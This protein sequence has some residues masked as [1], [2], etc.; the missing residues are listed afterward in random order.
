MRMWLLPG[1]RRHCATVKHST[2]TCSV[3]LVTKI[4]HKCQIILKYVY[5]IYK[6]N[7]ILQNQDREF[8]IDLNN[9]IGNPESK[10]GSPCKTQ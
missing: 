6:R 1:N 8:L 7:V 3:I 10:S 5:S 2:L 9:N 4:K